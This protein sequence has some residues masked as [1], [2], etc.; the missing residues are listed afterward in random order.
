MLLF[1]YLFVN[2]I[3]QKVARGFLLNLGLRLMT[4]EALIK[5]CKVRV[6]VVAASACW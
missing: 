3:I 2:R 6:I 4:R 1:V 5:F